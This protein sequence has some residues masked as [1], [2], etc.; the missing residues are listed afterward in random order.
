MFLNKWRV[1]EFLNSKIEEAEKKWPN[2]FHVGLCSGYMEVKSS[3]VEG[4]FDAGEGDENVRISELET[5]LK[6]SYDMLC[7]T[8][9][10][11]A[12]K[13][14]YEVIKHVRKVLCE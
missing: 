10:E 4:V 2:G 7:R 5:A 8:K 3:I 9:P 11:K 1:V 13:E 14:W 6:L 12:S